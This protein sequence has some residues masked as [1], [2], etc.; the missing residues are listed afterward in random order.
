MSA[1]EDTEHNSLGVL[2]AEHRQGWQLKL[3]GHI[4]DIV[5]VERRRHKL[6]GVVRKLLA[7]GYCPCRNSQLSQREHCLISM[8]T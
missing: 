2:L 3:V 8:D 7:A 1:V 6:I 4:V 5:A